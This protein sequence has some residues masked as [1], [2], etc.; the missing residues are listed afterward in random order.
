MPRPESGPD[1]SCTEGRP[2]SPGD[3]IA[4]MA[5]STRVARGDVEAR[6]AQIVHKERVDPLGVEDTDQTSHNHNWEEHINNQPS[7]GD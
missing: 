6:V 7:M 1:G 3:Q 5:T 4:D 2:V